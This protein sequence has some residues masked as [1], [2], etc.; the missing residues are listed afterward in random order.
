MMEDRWLYCFSCQASHPHHWT[1]KK[2]QCSN[3]EF[4]RISPDQDTPAID[5]DTAAA[6][7]WAG[8]AA[9]EGLREASDEKD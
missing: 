2:W 8:A 7:R 3:C 9:E 4:T 1:G 5:D 6:L